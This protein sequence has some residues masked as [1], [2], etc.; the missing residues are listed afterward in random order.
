MGEESEYLNTHIQYVRPEVEFLNIDENV[1]KNPPEVEFLNIDKKVGKK[2]HHS[3]KNPAF[4]QCSCTMSCTIPFHPLWH[5]CLFRVQVFKDSPMA[6]MGRKVGFSAF[7]PSLRIQVQEKGGGGGVTGGFLI[8][9]PLHKPRPLYS[10]P[11]PGGQPGYTGAGGPPGAP[12]SG[13]LQTRDVH[14]CM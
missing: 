6:A 5:S 2:P 3:E 9:G 10:P 13:K 14:Y 4:H 1:A 7:T 11:P 8:H 12:C